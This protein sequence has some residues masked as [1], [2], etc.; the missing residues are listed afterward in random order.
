[1]KLKT[2]PLLLTLAALASPASGQS[3]ELQVGRADIA[4]VVQATLLHGESSLPITLELQPM[5]ATEKAAA[6]AQAVAADPSGAWQAVADGSSLAFQH[7]VEGEWQGVDAVKDVS[8]DTG[9][10]TRL[11]GAGT[12]TTFTLELPEDVVASG[13]DAAG[14]PAVF[15]LTLTDTLTFT[16]ALQ[17]GQ[18]AQQVFDDLQTFLQDGAGAGVQVTRPGPASVIVSLAYA[19]SSFNWQVT[20]TVLRPKATGETDAGVIHR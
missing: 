12:L 1:M 9:S 18:T 17:A 19:E 13:L 5:S 14:Q 8:D 16:R 3:L 4:G 6:L 15:T 20:D 7:L 11:A 2:V 10:G